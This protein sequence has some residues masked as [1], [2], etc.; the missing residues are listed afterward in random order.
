MKPNA[1]GANL[2]SPIWKSFFQKLKD[3]GWIT[4][5]QMQRAS[6][7]DLVISKFSGKKPSTDTPPNRKSPTIANIALVPNQTETEIKQIQVDS[8]CN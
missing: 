1:F 6:V 7:Q 8:L 2:N 5:Q 4:P 3:R